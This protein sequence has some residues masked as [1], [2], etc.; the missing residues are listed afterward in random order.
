MEYNSAMINKN[1]KEAIF[2]KKAMEQREAEYKIQEYEENLAY[3]K[4]KCDE[5]KEILTVARELKNHEEMKSILR[6]FVNGSVIFFRSR[7]CDRKEEEL[8]HL[9]VRIS[10][11]FEKIMT[12][13]ENGTCLIR[14]LSTFN[15]VPEQ[16]TQSNA[17][18]FLKMFRSD[19]EN[20]Y[21]LFFRQ[22]EQEINAINNR[23][24]K[25]DVPYSISYTPNLITND[26]YDAAYIYLVE[27]TNPNVPKS[28]MSVPDLF[29][30][31][32]LAELIPEELWNWS[33]KDEMKS[34]GLSK[35]AAKKATLEWLLSMDKEEL[36]RR[37]PGKSIANAVI[38]K[39]ERFG[40]SFEEEQER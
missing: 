11:T 17:R 9:C 1:I 36:I 21:N 24:F 10:P 32:E 38:N 6:T 2:Q 3:L 18:A 37:I 8:A 23:S 19:F 39:A 31:A 7:E 28:S 20:F 13:T 14:Q 5:I 16:L 40:F 29:S 12:I 15:A 22:V 34:H 26:T 27:Q 33:I 25:N 35:A 30:K 4:S